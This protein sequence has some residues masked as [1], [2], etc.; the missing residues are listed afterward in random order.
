[1]ARRSP[2]LSL[3]LVT[4]YSAARIG[5]CVD[6]FRSQARGLELTLEIVIVDHSG[7]EGE[8]EAL[9]AVRPDRLLIRPNRGYAAG[10]NAGVA[11]SS[12]RALMLANPDIELLDGSLAALVDALAAGWS[13]VGP[14]QVWSPE[15]T[16]CLPVPEDPDPRAELRRQN[17]RASLR[18]WQSVVHEQLQSSWSF[19]RSAGVVAAPSLRGALLVLERQTWDRLGPLDEGYFLYYEE[20]EW[21]WR[22]RRA[23][24]RLGLVTRAAVVHHWG[25]ST[26]RLADRDALQQ[27]SY[28]RFVQRNYPWLSRWLL[29]RMQRRPSRV[30]VSSVEVQGPREVIVEGAELWQLS[31]FSHLMPSAGWL[32]ASVPEGLD[33]LTSEGRWFLMAARRHSEA[34]QIL[35]SWHWG[36]L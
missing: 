27:Q 2:D 21:L 20:T 30:G 19:W 35:G 22:A 15:G 1:M 28:L 16:V 10:L 7:D 11:E 9:R 32:G 31:P 23:G 3:V 14:R 34:W 17:G 25:H 36:D 29:K 26:E 33:R 24:E 6:S 18:T 13:V 5:P 4:Y 12:G 8:H